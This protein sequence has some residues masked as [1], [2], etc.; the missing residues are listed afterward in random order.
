ML[1][2]YYLIISILLVLLISIYSFIVDSVPLCHPLVITFY[3][4][5]FIVILLIILKK[6]GIIKKFSLPGVWGNLQKGRIILFIVAGIF[7]LL[8]DILSKV[9]FFY[10]FL[11]Q[12]VELIQNLGIQPFFHVDPLELKHIIVFILF[13]WLFL[14]GPVFY[15][16]NK[17]APD[18]LLIILCS[19]TFFSASGL[20]L[21]RIFFGGVHDVYY[22][23]GIFSI[24]CPSCGYLYSE[25]IFCP[26]D[27]FMSWGIISGS[28][29]YLSV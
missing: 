11:D 17:K 24:L 18:R 10:P 13:S 1:K 25:Y 6:R 7:V 22:A 15:R 19:I 14:I 29:Y 27:F 16:F 28:V 26:W 8:F 2:K 21:E 4:L 12:K 20:T 5:F 9:I 23:A 3:A